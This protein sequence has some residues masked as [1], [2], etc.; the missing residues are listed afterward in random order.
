MQKNDYGPLLVK[1]RRRNE[2]IR[3]VAGDYMELLAPGMSVAAWLRLVEDR[4]RQTAAML[5]Q[6][7]ASVDVPTMELERERAA[8][9]LAVSQ[10]G[11]NLFGIDPGINPG[12][13]FDGFQ[14]GRNQSVRAAVQATRIW[15]AGAGTPI[16]V[17]TGLPGVGK[18]HLLMAACNQ[19]TVR[20]QVA[21]FR[22]EA[23]LIAEAQR[24]VGDKTSE[25][26]LLEL[27]QVPH[28]ALDDFAL[29]ARTPWSLQ[30][31]DRVVNH[32]WA[33]QLRTIVS[34][35]V[36]MSALEPRL[37]SRLRDRAVSTV[38]TITA[39]DYRGTKR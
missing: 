8:R 31:M 1:L 28:L 35:N 10:D 20:G 26:F 19:L 5:R 7:V 32:R 30:V 13:T 38:I 17:L 2:G 27:C 21:L 36:T 34:T 4:D 11:E 25:E 18:T 33:Q 22:T 29:G 39:P 23:D 3:A 16:L 24:R 37:A 14:A 6:L 15:A 12:L 9:N